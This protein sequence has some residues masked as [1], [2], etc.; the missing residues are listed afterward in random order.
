MLWRVMRHSSSRIVSHVNVRPVSGCHSCRL[1]PLNSTGRPL[2]RISEPTIS[3]VRNP[4]RSRT[5]SAGVDTYASYKRGSSFDHGSTGPVHGAAGSTSAMPSS[6]TLR[7]AVGG[8][9]TTVSVPVPDTYEAWTNTSWMPP[10]GV[11]ISDTERKMPETCLLYTSDAADEEDS[12]DLG[13]R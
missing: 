1:T 11:A 13:G 7:R 8:S 12:V 9:A 4:M 2:R 6:G 10:S 5:V 3:T